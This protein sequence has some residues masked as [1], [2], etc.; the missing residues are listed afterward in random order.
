MNILS[1]KCNNPVELPGYS[2]NTYTDYNLPVS[3]RYPL[4]TGG[5]KKTKKKYKKMRYKKSKSVKKRKSKSVKKRKSK[6]VKKRKSMS[7]NK[8][9]SMS[10]NKRKLQKGGF[11]YPVNKIQTIYNTLL[12]NE[13]PQ[14]PNVIYDQFSYIK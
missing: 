4:F 9:K 6:S 10:L 2:L 12:G 1:S 14:S 11:L 5:N 8:R 13:L 7:L 3:T